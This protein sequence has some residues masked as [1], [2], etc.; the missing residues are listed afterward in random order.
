VLL[1]VLEAGAEEVNGRE[2]AFEVVCE[3]TD[4]HAVPAGLHRRRP[5]GASRR[6]RLGADPE[7]PLEDDVAVKVPALVDALED[8]DDVQ[9]VWA[10]F[11]VSDE[12][13][14]R[15][16]EVCRA[17]TFAVLLGVVGQDARAG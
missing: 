13:L 3:A 10:N 5:R 6:H 16:A 4:T 8:L 12:L 1:A 7:R 15:W 14:E 9:N 17:D 11:D 2:R